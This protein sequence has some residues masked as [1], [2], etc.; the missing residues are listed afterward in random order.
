[1]PTYCFD[2][3]ALKHRYT[4][5]KLSRR[6]S[7]IVSD[8]RWDVFVVEPTMLETVSALGDVSREKS[9]GVKRFDFMRL[10]FLDD[11]AHGRIKVRQVKIRDVRRAMH[12]I[13]Y[14]GVVLQRHLRTNDA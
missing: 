2:T 9:W 14:A 5:H 13:R 11:I 6:V 7:R 8:K 1:M 3:S 10:A 4:G 12:L